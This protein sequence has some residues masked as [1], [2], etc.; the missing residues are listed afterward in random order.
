MTTNIIET[1]NPS[2]TM[3]LL[4]E[5]KPGTFFRMSYMHELPVKAEFKKQ[6]YNVI[7]VT[8]VVTRTGVN[9]GNIQAV[10]DYKEAQAEAGIIP[11]ERHLD[12]EWI[13]KDFVQHNNKTN[14]DYVCIAPIG[15]IEETNKYIVVDPNTNVT[16]VSE[17]ELDKNLVRDSYFNSRNDNGYTMYKKVTID[18][19]ININGIGRAV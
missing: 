18:N 5:I 10:K 1:L 15:T 8:S 3:S 19:I 12:V 13:I 11:Q 4:K 16:T 17:E 7:K 6:G 9:Y 14:K 2:T